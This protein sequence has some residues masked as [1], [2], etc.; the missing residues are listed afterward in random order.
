MSPYKQRWNDRGY[1]THCSF[2]HSLC[3]TVAVEKHLKC[4]LVIYAEQKWTMVGDT[5]YVVTLDEC[6][7]WACGVPTFWLTKHIYN[8]E[9]ESC[10]FNR[11]HFYVCYSHVNILLLASQFTSCTGDTQTSLFA[12]YCIN[13]VLKSHS[14]VR[15]EKRL[16]G[17][18]PSHIMSCGIQPAYCD[19]SI[20]FVGV[21]QTITTPLRLM[22]KKIINQ[23]G[24]ELT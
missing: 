23:Q 24:D 20:A 19:Y 6:H 9:K 16:S 3:T 4:M 2:K 21:M 11:D 12:R 7:F 14:C 18:S 15:L 17:D 10:F 8:T 22:Q 5:L 13:W 1:I